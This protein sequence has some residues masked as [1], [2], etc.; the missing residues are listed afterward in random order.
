M[1]F[2]K[3]VMVVLICSLTLYIGH[4]FLKDPHKRKV[5]GQARLDFDLGGSKGGSF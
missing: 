1:G 2:H 4:V 5:I 3:K